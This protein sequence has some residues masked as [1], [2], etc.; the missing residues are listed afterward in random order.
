[1]GSRPAEGR[2]A[3]KVTG[4]AWHEVA[5]QM[6]SVRITHE[7]RKGKGDASHMTEPKA[8]AGGLPQSINQI[9]SWKTP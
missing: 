3:T 5:R 7:I 9:S 6:Q 1:V 4:E 2:F 8:T